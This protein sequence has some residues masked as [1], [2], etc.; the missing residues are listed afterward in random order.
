MINSKNL[1]FNFSDYKFSDARLER[2]TVEEFPASHIERITVNKGY[3]FL[4]ALSGKGTV[5]Y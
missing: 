1:D 2:C 5:Q 3:M 4:I